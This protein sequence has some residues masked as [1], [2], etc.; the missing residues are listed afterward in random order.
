MILCVIY[1]TIVT[2]Y[3]QFFVKNKYCVTNIVFKTFVVNRINVMH[4]D[5]LER[6]LN[7]LKLIANETD[8]ISVQIKQLEGLIENYYNKKKQKQRKLDLVLNGWKK[9]KNQ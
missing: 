8:E 4:I 7:K 3:M 1:C 6:K 2:Y 9:G 5:K